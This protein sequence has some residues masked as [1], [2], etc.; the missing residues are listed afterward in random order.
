M[1]AYKIFSHYTSYQK[2]LHAVSCITHDYCLIFFYTTLYIFGECL[3]VSW[4]DRVCA[5]CLSLSHSIARTIF[6]L[7]STNTICVFGFESSFRAS[8]HE[9]NVHCHKNTFS[10]FTTCCTLT[11]F[12]SPPLSFSR[13]LAS[14]SNENSHFI[15]K[16][17]P[18]I[19]FL[20]EYSSYIDACRAILTDGGGVWCNVSVKC[21][22]SPNRCV[23]HWVC[24]SYN[25]IQKMYIKMNAFPVLSRF[26]TFIFTLALSK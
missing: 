10:S 4:S 7:V 8:D 2:T 14:H 12:P 24:L 1:C 15:R 19:W 21:F 18:S 25:R 16:L 6:I 23:W 26:L 17:L 20:I 13:F 9:S 11:L 22:D 3:H 5:R